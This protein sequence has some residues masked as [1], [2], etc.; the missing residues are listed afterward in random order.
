MMIVQSPQGA[1]LEYT[2]N[3]CAQVEKTLAGVHEIDGV[4][5]VTGFSFSGSAPNRAIVFANLKAVPASA[6]EKRIPPQA[7]IERLRPQ[8][9]GIPGAL[10]IPFNP[11]AVQGLG[12]F[13]GFQFELE[14][15]GRNSP[16][17][18][19]P[20][21]RTNWSGK[22]TA[23]RNLTGLFTSFTANDPQYLV[24][25]RSRKSQEPAS[26][27]EPD[28]RRAAGLHGLGV[29]ERFRFQQ[30]LVS[31]LCTSRRTFPSQRQRH[32]SILFA[33]GYRENDP[34]R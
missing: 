17:G 23:A 25:T 28:H 33:I 2:R 34:A 18:A 32:R 13:G 30:S 31:R 24:R 16:A 20:I 5:S 3:I 22:A 4:F 9:F 12:Q 1:S 14:D 7:I 26:A 8:L 19:S 29:C 6:K 15:L 11:P 10:V 21:P 27:A